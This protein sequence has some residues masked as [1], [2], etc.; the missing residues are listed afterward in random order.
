MWTAPRRRVADFFDSASDFGKRRRQWQM[1]P[2]RTVSGIA[3]NWNFM[4]SQRCGNA[5]SQETHL[6]N[7]N[8]LNQRALNLTA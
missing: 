3:G 6:S 4:V 1:A 7:F 2:R 8:A 5:A